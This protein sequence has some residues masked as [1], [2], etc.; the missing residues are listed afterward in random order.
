MEKVLLPWLGL[1]NPAQLDAYLNSLPHRYREKARADYAAGTLREHYL[2]QLLKLLYH[3]ARDL[4]SAMWTHG[5]VKA[6]FFHTF[7]WTLRDGQF[8]ERREDDLTKPGGFISTLV[9]RL[10]ADLIQLIREYHFPF[11][12]CPVCGKVFVPVKRQKFCS[13]NC[14]Y[15]GIAAVGKDARRKYMKNYM[16]NRRK[17]AKTRQKRKEV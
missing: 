15:R 12:V 17:K 1:D 13:P 9:E 6:T 5:E 7:V 4:I 10:E 2:P 16:A 3:R 11:R 8:Q 14:T